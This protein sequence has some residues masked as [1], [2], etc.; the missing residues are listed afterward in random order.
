MNPLPNE[1][2]LETM[3]QL[4][5]TPRVERAYSS[6]PPRSRLGAWNVFAPAPLVESAEASQGL[7]GLPALLKY[8]GLI[9][10]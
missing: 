1:L 7:P 9:Q 4:A 6:R 5:L 10:H 2:N 3:M 8:P